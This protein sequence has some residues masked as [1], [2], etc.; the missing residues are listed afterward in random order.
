[1]PYCFRYLKFDEDDNDFEIVCARGKDL[2]FIT[3]ETRQVQNFSTYEEMKPSLLKYFPMINP[4][5]I[6]LALKHFSMPID[7][8]MKLSSKNKS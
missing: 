1:M 8:A 6:E 7:E 4:V 3:R 2:I 5:D